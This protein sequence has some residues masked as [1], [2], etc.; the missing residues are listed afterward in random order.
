MSKRLSLYGVNPLDALR[1]ALNT[2]M[3]KEKP[4]KKA[5]AKA[6]RTAKKKG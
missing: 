5:R 4:K 2:P 1:I 3:P 6:K